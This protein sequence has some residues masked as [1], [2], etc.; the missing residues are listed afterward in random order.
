MTVPGKGMPFHKQSYKTG[1]LYVVFKVKFPASINNTE[2]GLIKSALGGSK[3]DSEMYDST[4]E[5]A[6][7]VAYSEE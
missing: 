2:L 4:I 1:N 3:S 5:V 7:L 6:Q